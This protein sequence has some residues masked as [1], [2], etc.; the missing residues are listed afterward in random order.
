MKKIVRT[1]NAQNLM[2]LRNFNPGASSQFIITGESEKNI[3]G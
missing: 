1:L 3:G 2:I